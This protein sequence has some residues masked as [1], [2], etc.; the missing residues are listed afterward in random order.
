MTMNGLQ[1]LVALTVGIVL[2]GVTLAPR[3]VVAQDEPCAVDIQQFCKQEAAGK[4]RFPLPCLRRHEGE[5]S[6]ACMARLRVSTLLQ[7]MSDYLAETPQFTFEA[8][9]TEEDVL[10]SGQKL[11]FGG[12]V[13]L[14][15][16]RPH[17]FR[18]DSVWARGDRRLWY[19]GSHMTLQDN[20]EQVYATAKAPGTIDKALDYGQEQLGITIPLA[21]LLTTNPYASLLPPAQRLLDVMYVGMDTV[22]GRPCHHLAV[23]LEHIDW[24]IWIE[25][26]AT[27]VPRKLVLTYTKEPSQ[28]QY[29]A[30]FTT[31]DLSPR[32]SDA[33]FHFVPPEDMEAIAFLALEESKDTEA[34][35]VG[36]QKK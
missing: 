21:D 16:R 28:P 17:A 11:Q 15:L 24:Q 20:R 19:D 3:A 32:L 12:T 35:P 10:A 2:S 18:L 27:F 5:L 1:R 6:A 4:Q 8:A 9:F 31:W 25:D 29:T 7:Q 13:R 14:V 23:R 36:E 34:P 30:V 33:L 26:G 22:Q